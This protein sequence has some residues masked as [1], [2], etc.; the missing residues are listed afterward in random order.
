MRKKGIHTEST[1]RYILEKKLIW[2]KEDTP[3]EKSW[4]CRNSREKKGILGKRQEF[5][6]GMKRRKRRCCREKKSLEEKGKW[7]KKGRSDFAKIK[8]GSRKYKERNLHLKWNP[9]ALK[10]EM[11]PCMCSRGWRSRVLYFLRP[12]PP[13]PP[14]AA[15]GRIYEALELSVIGGFGQIY[16]Q[17]LADV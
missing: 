1:C 2:R 17:G 14:L 16:A 9:V 12:L 10:T 8:D 7:I 4:I 15:G 6:E 3:Q 13:P 11:E 5:L